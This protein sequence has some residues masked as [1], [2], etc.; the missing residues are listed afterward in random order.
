MALALEVILLKVEDIRQH[1]IGELMDSNFVIDKTGVKTIEMIGATFEADEPTIFGELNED[2][3]QRELDW[4]KSM[5]LYVDDIPGITP[6]IWQQVADRGGKINSNYGWAIYHK[7][8][9]LQYA[10]VLNELQF[11]PNS[12]RAVMIY[13]RPTMWND[14][15]RDGMSDFMCTNTVQY[16]IRDEQLIVIVQMRSNDV[17]FGYRNDYAWQKYV[18]FHMTKDLKLTKQPKIIWHVGSLHVY[19]RHFDKVK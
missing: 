15:N 13:T 7:D 17:V 14:Y 6:A 1:F 4:Y 12:R 2:Y 9:H 19:E 5:S 3:I 10:N 18:A 11:S 16:M 8:N